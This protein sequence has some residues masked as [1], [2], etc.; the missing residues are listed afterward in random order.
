M[1]QEILVAYTY[2]TLFFFFGG[3]TPG[4]KLL[5]LKMVKRD[6]SKLSFWGAFER[7]HG[8]AYS[9]SLAMIGFLQILWDKESITMHDEIAGTTVIRI[10]RSGK[11]RERK[12][13]EQKAK[14]VRNQKI[15]KVGSDNERTN[16]NLKE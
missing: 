9:T 8:Y 11:K 1:V 6:G 13:K 15:A 5:G 12:R 7:T 10:R 16:F 3:R 2:F 4:K 14:K